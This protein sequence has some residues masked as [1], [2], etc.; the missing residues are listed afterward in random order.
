MIAFLLN[1]IWSLAMSLAY[2]M[3]GAV[4]ALEKPAV[5]DEAQRYRTA[6]VVTLLLAFPFSTG[7]AIVFNVA[8]KEEVLFNVLGFT[9]IVLVGLS[10]VLGL[11]YGRVNAVSDS[12]PSYRR[13]QR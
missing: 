1:L 13:S 7:A 4:E 8:P 11:V 10:L 9:G 6:A 3:I 2:R 5:N 12:K